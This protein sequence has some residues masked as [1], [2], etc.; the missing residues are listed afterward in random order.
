MTSVL[1]TGGA[2]FIG[3]HLSEALV[4]RGDQV[5]VLDNFSSGARHNLA[6]IAEHI[7]LV[8]ED[9]RDADALA[10]VL[11]GVEVVFHQA[12][13]VSVP[14]SIVNPADCFSINVDGVA[15]LLSA[16]RRAGVAR[17]VLASSAAVYGAINQMPL[18]E[19]GPT[20]ILSP[21]AA[22]KLFNETLAELYTHG[23]GLPTV[24][25]RYFNVFGLRQSPNSDYAAVIPKFVD[26][27][28]VGEAPVVFGD[29]SQSRDF[30]YV[31][32]VV[33]ANLLAAEVEDAPGKAINICSGKETTLIA[34]LQILSSLFPAAL[35]PTFA[36]ARLGDVP[37]SVGDPSR[38]TEILEF[39]TQVSLAEGL[40]QSVGASA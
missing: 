3:S 39:Q 12:A 19:T 37:R 8:E 25:L 16:A 32:D 30:V 18:N 33:R 14:E 22:S 2:G 40:S 6:T 38:A 4:Q 21:Y 11:N 17:V 23:Y 31:G 10:R 34:L 7:E 13:F 26:R 35:P 29:G 20:Q 27:M 24:A 15:Q 36:E 28:Q 5:R 9:L 1:V